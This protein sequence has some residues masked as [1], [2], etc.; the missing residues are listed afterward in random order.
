M[1]VGTRP[2]TSADLAVVAEIAEA[3]IGELRLLRGGEVWANSD[4][5]TTP[6]RT[7]LES[8]LADPNAEIFVGTIDGAPVDHA[9]VH[10]R[11]FTMA[12]RWLESP[13]STSSLRLAGLAVA[14]L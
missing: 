4:G 6:V 9:A 1:I 13:I 3:A 8:E 14:N 10:E 5:R 7:G 11:G 2:A 12:R